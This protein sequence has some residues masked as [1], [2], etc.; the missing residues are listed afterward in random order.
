M[1]PLASLPD[2]R[3]ASTQALMEIAELGDELDEA[4]LAP[5]RAFLEAQ[6]DALDEALEKATEQSVIDQIQAQQNRL[7]AQANALTGLS[8]LLT[9]GE[10]RVS[11]AHI[12]AAVDGARQAIDRVDS[13][14]ARLAKL[15]AVIE[16]TAAL[17]SGRGKAIVEAA[18]ALKATLDAPG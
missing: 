5:L 7:A 2:P 6:A 9:A 10:A 14:K 11:A 12:Q 16:F 17:L 4:A 13:L 15:G 8:I 1:S 18:K 3:P